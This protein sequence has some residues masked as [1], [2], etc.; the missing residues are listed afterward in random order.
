MLQQNEAFPIKHHLIK[1]II[2]L[3]MLMDS[4]IN[5]FPRGGFINISFSDPASR[6]SKEAH[7]F[8]KSIFNKID[9]IL[10]PTNMVMMKTIGDPMTLERN[11]I[12]KSLEENIIRLSLNEHK[13]TS[14]IA[15]SILATSH[16][17]L[18]MQS[19]FHDWNIKNNA[20]LPACCYIVGVKRFIALRKTFPG[21]LTGGKVPIERVYS[22]R[23]KPRK[24]QNALSFLQTSLQIRPGA[25]LS[26]RIADYNFQGLPV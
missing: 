23:V 19:F 26:V 12:K 1:L 24:V 3:G 2:L 7:N 10:C 5:R 18:E 8:H 17:R 9:Q 14:F 4:N 13:I 6:Y 25:V 20:Y 11:K 22:Y 16:T 21:L 15:C